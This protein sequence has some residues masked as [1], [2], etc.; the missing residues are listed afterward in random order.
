MPGE[1]LSHLVDVEVAWLEVSGH[2][3]EIDENAARLI[4]AEMPSLTKDLV[5]ETRH[6]RD[7]ARSA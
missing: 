6:I 5:H 3:G 2:V 4:A 7:F 1:L